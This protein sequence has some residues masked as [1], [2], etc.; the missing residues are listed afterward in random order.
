MKR[1]WWLTALGFCCAAAV[2]AQSGCAESKDLVVRALEIVSAQPSSDDL[3]T[4][5]ELLKHAEQMCDENG[6]A[7]YYRSLFERKMGHAAQADYAYKN[8]Q[9]RDSEAQKQ[10]DNPFRLATPARGV[11]VDAGPATATVPHDPRVS[12]IKPDV[13]RKWALV[14]GISNFGD[15]HLNLKFSVKDADSFASLLRDPQ[16]GRFHADHV[17]VVRDGEATTQR[18]KRELIWLAQSAGPDDLAVIYIATHGSARQQDAAGLS[19]VVTYDSDVASEAG[20]YSTALPM[21]EVSNLVRTRLHAEKVAVF[22]DTCH[23]AGAISQTV[24]VP[25]S[26]SPELLKHI[27]EGTGRVILAASQEDES[28]YEDP[29]F[30][31]GVFT[32]YLL[33]ALKQQNG[34]VQLRQVYDYVREQM[35][36]G[37]WKQHPVMSRSD[38]ES[39][40]MLGVPQLSSRLL[41]LLPMLPTE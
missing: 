30:G 35:G 18:I 29:R 8:A 39:V 33:Q 23:S 15:P 25:A 20:L 28:S 6:D 14:I 7:W 3:F 13:S 41:Q 22:L 9:R 32:Y 31:H 26:A 10:A 1:A 24:T 34:N 16:Y 38:D 40:L 21:V 2:Y 27:R 4:G 36:K 12:A 17:H 19:Y 37:G 11:T 5:L